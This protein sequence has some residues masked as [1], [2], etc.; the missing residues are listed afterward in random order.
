VSTHAPPSPPR[1]LADAPGPPRTPAEG[2][3]AG[4]DRTPL[5]ANEAFKAVED[6]LAVRE[7][8]ERI[9]AVEGFDS[10]PADDLRGRFRWWGIYTQRK[11]GIDGGR[12][13]T[14]EPEELEDRH[15][16][17]RIRCDGGALDVAQLRTIAGISSEFARDTADITDRQNI[18]LHWIRIEEVP[19]IFRRLE[20]AGLQT[21]EACGDCP[22]VIL[23]SPLAGVAADE[24]VDPSPAIAEIIR[25]FIGDPA[26]SNLPRKFKTAITGMPVSDVVHEI[27]DVSFVAVRHPELG[28]GYDLW[29]GGALSTNPRLAVRLGAWVAPDRVPEVWAAVVGVFRDH[30]YRR[31]RMKARM[32]FL[33]ADWG[34]EHFRTVLERDYLG[35]PL[36]DGPA[37]AEPPPGERGDH[38]G[39]HRQRDGRY[40]V[41]TAPNVGR[42]S[43]AVLHGIA[44]LVEAAGSD[45]I[46]LTPQQK[47]VVLDVAEDRLG[48]LT[49]GL[50]ALDLQVAPGPF[51]RHTMA[52]TGLEFCKMAIVETKALA[53]ATSARLDAAIGS[54]LD[55]PVSVHVNGCPNSCVRIQTADIGLKGQ[56]V[57]TDDGQQVE[58]FQV[59]LGGRLGQDA[60]FGRKVRGHKVTALELP[61]YVERVT[62]HYLTDRSAD[63]S[64]A[65]WAV[66]ADEE[67]LT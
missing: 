43:G 31:L 58:G 37:P 53:A 9:Y 8:I 66:R 64:F 67:A 63:E 28:V 7:R 52:C 20:A 38:V 49:S 45:R 35:A 32:K 36:P 50:E 61:A 29:V 65:Q 39:V 22:R 48:T 1:R 12:T 56:I 59:H 42:V 15:F 14:L 26:Y 60:D 55:V 13:A 46:R 6:P 18:Q 21:T 34:A 44:D 3:W 16:L 24:L 47:L 41:G 54:E 25:R 19:E 27:N 11:P 5:N 62:R 30:G 40:Y 51:R 23:G 4:G 33:L 10:I 17:L 2:Q 57:T